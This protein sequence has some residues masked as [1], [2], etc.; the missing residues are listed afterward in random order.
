MVSCQAKKDSKPN[1]SYVG[2][3][4]KTCGMGC[5][6]S[7]GTA[8]VK[9]QSDRELGGISRGPSRGNTEIE[10]MVVGKTKLKGNWR[11]WPFENKVFA[12]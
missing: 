2:L 11:R 12:S 8:R 7:R 5:S 4:K 6:V 10:S 3:K 9:Q 1:T